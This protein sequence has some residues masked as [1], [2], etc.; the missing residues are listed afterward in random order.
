MTSEGMKPVAT[1]A[2]PDP[3]SLPAFCIF[4]YVYFARP[5]STFEGISCC[6][7]ISSVVV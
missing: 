5:D 2:R 7:H 1:V 6:H 4:E 3:L